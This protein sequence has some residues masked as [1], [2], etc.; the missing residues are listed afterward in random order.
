MH[1]SA[2]INH[3][4]GIHT[5]LYVRDPLFGSHR[6]VRDDHDTTLHIVNLFFRPGRSL[7]H[8]SDGLPNVINFALRADDRLNLKQVSA[9][10]SPLVAQSPYQEEFIRRPYLLHDTSKLLCHSLGIEQMLDTTADRLPFV[11]CVSYLLKLPVS[12]EPLALLPQSPVLL[13]VYASRSES[14]ARKR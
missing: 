3:L 7:V 14:G 1:T 8:D 6:G 12:R 10:S 4:D 13:T 2:R 9:T 5:L 11:G